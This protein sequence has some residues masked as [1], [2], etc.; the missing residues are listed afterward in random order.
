MARLGAR[1]NRLVRHDFPRKRIVRGRHIQHERAAILERVG[2][3]EQFVGRE[4]GDKKPDAR[5]GKLLRRR[6]RRLIRAKD[7]LVEIE[8]LAQKGSGGVVVH[9]RQTGALQGFVGRSRR[10]IVERRSRLF[11][12]QDADDDIEPG[13]FRADGRRRRR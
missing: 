13:W 3:R 11:A 4:V 1:W 6:D 8:M 10:G 5:I 2:D 7:H 12:R 9:L